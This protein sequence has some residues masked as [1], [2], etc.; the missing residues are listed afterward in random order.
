L[1]KEDKLKFVASTFIYLMLDS[2]KLQQAFKNEGF[3]FEKRL[4][5]IYAETGNINFKAKSA[6]RKIFNTFILNNNKNYKRRYIKL[7]SEQ[8]ENKGK[9]TNEFSIEIK[10]AGSKE[11]VVQNLREI[12]SGI[13]STTLQELRSGLNWEDATLITTTNLPQTYY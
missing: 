1:A 10:G 5:T 2:P 3:D 6:L 9:K 11:K 12:I 7:F 13:E 4:M 8:E